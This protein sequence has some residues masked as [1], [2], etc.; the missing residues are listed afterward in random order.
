MMADGRYGDIRACDRWDLKG[1]HK[2]RG[3]RRA[4]YSGN[5]FTARLDGGAIWAK[6]GLFKPSRTLNSLLPVNIM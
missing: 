1:Q 3:S 2:P 4:Y 5:K 6:K